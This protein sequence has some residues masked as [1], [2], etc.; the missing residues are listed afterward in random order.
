MNESSILQAWPGLLRQVLAQVPIVQG[1]SVQAEMGADGDGQRLDGQA[2]FTVQGEPH[3][4]LIECKT[5]AQPRQVRGAVSQLARAVSRSPVPCQGV[6]AAPF[7]SPASRAILAEAGLGWLDLA[8]NARIALP[9]LHVEISKAERDPTA[10]RRVQRSLF[11]PKSARLLKLLLAQPGRAW[12]VADLAEAAGVSLGQVSNVR[13][14]LVERE[15]ATADAAQGLRL[16]QPGALLDAW[17]DAG[18]KPAAVKLPGYTL[19]NGAALQA[20]LQAAFAEAAQRGAHLLLASHSVARR[21]APFVR[22]AGEFFYADAAGLAILQD[23]LKL[24]RAHT[25]ANVTVYAAHD[26]GLWQAPM[27]LSAGLQGTGPVQTYLDLWGGGERS[28][29]AAEHWR[30]ELIDKLWEST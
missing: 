16:V 18:E 14:A 15:W 3:R 5:T 26:D 28:R 25:G 30:A 11:Y 4:L 8:G 7:V 22:V 12:R 21:A 24:Q 17:R 6:L 9:R 19:L 2:D 23:Q 20:A 13:Q 10:T 29:E 1:L 27:P